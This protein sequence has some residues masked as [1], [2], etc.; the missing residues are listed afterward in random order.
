MKGKIY[1]IYIVWRFEAKV[2]T[3]IIIEERFL[4]DT[5]KNLPLF[6]IEEIEVKEYENNK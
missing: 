4:I 6:E 2:E 1:C 3:K 5:I